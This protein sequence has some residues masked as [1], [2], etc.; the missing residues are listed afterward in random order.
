MQEQ[1]NT[2][3]ILGVG[4]TL[5]PLEFALT[6]HTPQGVIFIASQD[7]QVVSAE[8]IQRYGEAL[9]FHTLLLD[10]PEDLGE[11]FRKGRL[12][13]Q[14]AL[15]WEARAIVADITGGTKTMSAG[16]VLALTGQGV[17]FSYV[18]GQA[19]DGQGRVKSGSERLRLLED[20]TYRYGLREWEGFRRAWNQ[21]DYRAA[22]EF[23]DELL[24]RPLTPSEKRF[25][26]HLKGITEGMLEWD[27]FYHKAAWQKLERHLEPA[28]A[29]AEAWGHGAKVRALQELQQA[30]ARLRAILDREGKPTFA[31]LADLLANAQR[32][33]SR[34]RH[35]DALARLYRAV[36][37]AAE[38]DLYERHQIVLSDPKSYPQAAQHLA[39]QIQ[40][41]TGLKDRLSL[42]ATI[43][44]VLG[45]SQTLPQR[46]YAA[47][48]G[49]L[50]NLLQ[51]RHNSILA[52]GFTPVKQESWEKLYKSLQGLGLEAAPAWP[53]W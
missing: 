9:R 16:L 49:E 28:L 53:T 10:D 1:L 11:V 45:Q 44:G 42:A 6:E 37:L 25:Y 19:R 50:G 36:E 35:D 27:L 39:Q 5:E 52:H 12:A 40:R 41:A 46:L 4:Q 30:Q 18:G 3:L 43:D 34:G 51:A 20:P 24:A 14:K 8:L 32:R 26:D 23:L 2:V 48:L 17:T 22:Q 7:S 31:L 13:L 29:I 38:A 47:Y 21:C 15:E 33:A